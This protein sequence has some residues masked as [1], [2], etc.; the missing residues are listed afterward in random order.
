LLAERRNPLASG[1]QLPG[2]QIALQ[3]ALQLEV[4]ADEVH[5]YRA[6]RLRGGHPRVLRAAGVDGQPVGA[7]VAEVA[8]LLLCELA[9]ERPAPGRGSDV[10]VGRAVDVGHHCGASHARPQVCLRL[11]AC[12]PRKRCY[13]ARVGYSRWG[14]ANSYPLSTRAHGNGVRGSSLARKGQSASHAR[15]DR[16]DISFRATQERTVHEYVWSAQER[17]VT[18]LRHTAGKS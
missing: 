10:A 11:Q 17:Y 6:H 3:L 1:V 8:G 14:F 7:R 2:G 15:W 5:R 12:P 13:F 16:W 9:A 18:A 4:Q